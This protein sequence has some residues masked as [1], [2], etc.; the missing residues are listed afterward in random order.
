M[1]L[2]VLDDD[3]SHV[4]SNSTFNKKSTF[5]RLNIDSKKPKYL[6]FHVVFNIVIVVVI[7]F[8]VVIVI[9]IITTKLSAIVTDHFY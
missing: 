6:A 8:V 9:N 4:E 1:T 7:S 5:I 2:S 3:I